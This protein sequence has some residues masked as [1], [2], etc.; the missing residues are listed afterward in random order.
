MCI[1]LPDAHDGLPKLVDTMASQH[2]FMHK[3]LPVEKVNVDEF[4]VPKFKLSFESSVVTI[5]KKLGLR[6]PF[7][8]E[9]DLSDMV[10]DEVEPDDSRM[11]L[12]V[13]EVMHKAVI[14]VNEEGTK[15]AAVTMFHVEYF[16][17]TIPP[18]GVDFVADHP[19]AYFIMEEATSA[20]IFA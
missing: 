8:E 16:C 18:P 7:G 12:V 20:I 2:G 15:A 6:L 19:F 4:R 14:E 10:E 13:S 1:F 3:H 9:A 5:L 11:P 17:A